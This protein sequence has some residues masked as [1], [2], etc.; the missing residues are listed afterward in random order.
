MDIG[1]GIP[2][3]STQALSLWVAAAHLPYAQDV[4]GECGVRA[5]PTFQAFFNGAK[6]DELTG[7]DPG[8]LQAMVAK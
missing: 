7:A 8:R 5:M 6:V 2:S 3:N 1:V 4:A